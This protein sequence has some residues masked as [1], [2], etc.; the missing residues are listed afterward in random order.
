[1]INFLRYGIDRCSPDRGRA[2]Y[3]EIDSVNPGSA[4]RFGKVVD[5]PGNH[6]K[7]T[8]KFDEKTQ[9]YWSITNRSDTGKPTRRNELILISSEDTENWKTEK[10]LLDYESN[11]WYE[12]HESVGFQYV[13]FIFYDNEILYVSRTALNGALNFHD[14]NCI[15]FHRTEY[16]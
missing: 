4:P 16:R 15:T 12:S 10:V 13:D 8:I 2:L 5:F 14:S 11:G 9:K 7:F 3:L 6:S 1:M